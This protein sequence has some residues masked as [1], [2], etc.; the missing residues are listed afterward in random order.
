MAAALGPWQSGKSDSGLSVRRARLLVLDFAIA[1]FC[2]SVVVFIHTAGTN[3]IRHW[4]DFTNLV[5]KYGPIQMYSHKPPGSFYN[6]PPLMGYV[7]EIV[8]FN[9]SIGIPVR[10]SIRAA[11]SLADIATALIVFELVRQRRTQREATACG[12]LVAVSP[13]LFTISA[14]HG[15]T[16]PIFTMLVLLSLYLILDRRAPAWAGAVIALG[17]GVKIVAVVALPCLLVFAWTRGRR[18]FARFCAGLVGVLAVSWGPAVLLNWAQ[19]KS[20]VLDYSG[21]GLGQWG[22]MQFGHW[23]GDPGWVAWMKGPGHI[24]IVAFCALLP[25]LAVWRRPH[26]VMIA[27]AL[28]LALFLTLSPAFAVQ[29]LA[30]PAAATAVIGFWRGLMYNTAAGV[31]L[32]A[33]YARWSHAFPWTSHMA[34]YSPSSEKET[35]FLVLVWA[36]LVFTCWKAIKK[37]FVLKPTESSE[38]GDTVRRPHQEQAEAGAR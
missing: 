21:L 4:V 5:S 6:H 24:P 23:A 32:F 10:V 36:I 34:Y 16:D 28:S 19:L 27:V 33:E 30:W 18:S 25:A 37:I 15:N 35:V 14:F 2:V 26:T 20:H 8:D 1:V 12:I 13:V 38:S 17:I 31:L 22:L 11:A 7:L 29:Y 9:R 3:D